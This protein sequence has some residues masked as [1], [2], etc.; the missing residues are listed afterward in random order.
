MNDERNFIARAGL[1][2][3]WRLMLWLREHCLPMFHLLRFGKLNVN[4]A[5]HW[6]SAWERHGR[7]GFRATGELTNVRQFVVEAV[8]ERS[9]VLDVGCGV[10]ETLDLLAKEKCAECHGV[11]VSDFA[12]HRI[13]ERGYDGRVAELP[14]IPY[15]N[16]SFDVV[17]CTETL[18]HVTDT[19]RTIAEFRRVLRVTGKLLLSVPDGTADDED[20]HVRRFNAGQLRRVLEDRF[21][22]LR[23]DRLDENGTGLLFVIAVPRPN[24]EGSN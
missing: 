4:D 15:P 7:D 23:L 1:V 9:S 14:R 6:N 3:P 16:A 24:G 17:V 22:V 11:D 10:G 21:D 12:I 8:P 20:V 18:E 19:K 5:S 13:V 2:L